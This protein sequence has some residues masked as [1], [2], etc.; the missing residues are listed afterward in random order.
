MPAGLAARGVT[1]LPPGTAVG[2]LDRWSPQYILVLG[3][4]RPRR[5]CRSR[6]TAT[7]TA[8][9]A[10]GSGVIIAELLASVRGHRVVVTAAS[11]KLRRRCVAA[12][13][14]GAAPRWL[15]NLL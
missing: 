8:A 6:P 12:G 7:G 11:A 2:A 9:A 15:L 5:R 1:A 13:A 4:G 14:T 10:P 3:R